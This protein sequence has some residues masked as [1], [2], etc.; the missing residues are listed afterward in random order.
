MKQD[1]F[2]VTVHNPKTPDY[3]SSFF[4]SV[5][6]TDTIVSGN[7]L[8]ALLVAEHFI[9][10]YTKAKFIDIHWVNKQGDTV[11]HYLW[12]RERDGEQMPDIEG[13]EEV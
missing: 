13:L 1:M 6:G 4:H 12:F 9:E 11:A 7:G 3:M 5:N 2:I 10:F 8:S